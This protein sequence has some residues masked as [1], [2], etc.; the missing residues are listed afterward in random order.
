MAFDDP[1]LMQKLFGQS[2]T[3]PPVTGIPGRDLASS[4][5]T[6]DAFQGDR[7]GTALRQ[8]TSV[9]QGITPDDLARADALISKMAG[10]FQNANI[11]A[12]LPA[13]NIPNFW[14]SP[15]DLSAQVTVPGVVQP[16]YTT[17]LSWKCQEGTRTRITGYGVKVETPG[18]TYD[19]SLLW[20]LTLNGVQIG[21]LYGWGQQ[22]GSI[23]SPRETFIIMQPGDFLQFQVRRAALT[24]GAPAWAP[25]TVYAPGQLV[26][27]AGN[28][29]LA[30]VGGTSAGSGG[31]TT[32]GTAI[33]DGTV[34]WDYQ[35]SLSGNLV[36][37]MALTGYFWKPRRNYEGARS[38][39][40]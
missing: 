32:S 30:V 26:S 13:F 25:L 14:S 20:Q 10:F 18:Y 1:A 36:V 8:D 12:S 24:A 4:D 6:R 9:P 28:T 15:I 35:G 34:R 5:A 40:N 27:N 3:I 21:S 33:V 31:P 22:R 19:G 38:G 29:Y 16:N 17:V 7:I 39:V 23:V 2:N 11:T 37:D